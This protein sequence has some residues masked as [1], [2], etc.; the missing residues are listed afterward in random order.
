LKTKSVDDAPISISNSSATCD[1][2]IR[3][4]AGMMSVRLRCSFRE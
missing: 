3:N 2:S 1:G 4:R